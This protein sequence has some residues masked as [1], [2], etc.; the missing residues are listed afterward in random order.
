MVDR[1]NLIKRLVLNEQL[2]IS[3]ADTGEIL[4][5]TAPCIP[6]NIDGARTIRNLE[7]NIRSLQEEI[8][9]HEHWK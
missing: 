8:M 6:V 5:K 9:W 2:Q 1:L 3:N 4:G 7:E